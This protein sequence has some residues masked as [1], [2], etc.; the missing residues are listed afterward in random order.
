MRGNRKSERKEDASVML[1]ELSKNL[2][3]SAIASSNQGKTQKYRQNTTSI[4]EIRT[5]NLIKSVQK[6]NFKRE[7]T[8]KIY[9]LEMCLIVLL[10]S[11]FTLHK[12]SKI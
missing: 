4:Q 9:S 10:S 3:K 2:I 5:K 11:F 1:N 6:K 7:L 12:R 8:L